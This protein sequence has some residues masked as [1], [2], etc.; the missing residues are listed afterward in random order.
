V[1]SRAD[2]SVFERFP[3]WRG[4]PRPGCQANWLG[5]Q[6]AVTLFPGLDAPPSVETQTS[7][8]PVDEE[9]V[10][11][12]DLLEA[13]LAARGRF[14][15]LELGAG[16]GRW[17]ANA[18]A[19]CRHVGVEYQF[20]G[21]EAEPTHFAWM[22]DHLAAN[23]VDLAN[24]SLVEAAVAD[25]DGVVRFRTGAAAT[26]YGQRILRSRRE[27]WNWRLVWRG[28][29]R[30]VRALS[31]V[32]LLRDIDAVEVD[33]IDLD[34]QSAEADVLEPA[35]YLLDRR[36]RR[37]HVATHPDGGE[38]RVRRLFERLGWSCRFDYPWGQTSDTPW[39]SIHFQDGVQS[40]LNPA[41][42]QP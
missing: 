34:V 41:L 20:V 28:R 37:V 16:W 35:A 42:A 32:S 7:R 10:E 14:V 24:V 31:L 17:I 27:A 19:A 11:W 36:V 38:E 5:V 9:Y 23:G 15:M 21:V 29:V 8:P 39:G 2:D 18:A 40:W 12:I 25:R 4:I 26:C 13:V 3:P 1:T 22:R 33:L 30:K 6:T